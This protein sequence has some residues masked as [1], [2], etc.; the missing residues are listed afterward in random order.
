[1]RKSENIEMLELAAIQLKQIK[2]KLV[3]VGGST[4]DLYM[5]DAG[6]PGMRATKDVDCV[7]NITSK[8]EFYKLAEEV[9]LLGFEHVMGGPICRYKKNSTILDIMPTNSEILGFSNK[10]Y[11]EGIENKINIQLP[12]KTNINIFSGP[13]FI[14]SKLEAFKG[15]GKGDYM[16]SHDLEDIVA[17]LDGK[18]DIAGEIQRAPETVRRYLQNEFNQLLNNHDYIDSLD[19]HIADRQN[20]AGRRE[21]VIKRMGEVVSIDK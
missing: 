13:Y 19:G 1:M 7:I 9:K 15:R 17:I 12:H 21:V 6:Q 14:A 2:D 3:F 5:S 11:P 4:L 10:W 8:T 16:G 18:N 20:I